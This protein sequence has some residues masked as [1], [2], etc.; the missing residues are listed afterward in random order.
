MM[1]LTN[2][3]QVTKEKVDQCF[4]SFFP[5]KDEKHQEVSEAVRYSFLGSG[6]ALRPF[7]VLETAKLFD[8]PES[9]AVHVACA[10]EM[11]HTY[12]LIHDDLPSMDNDD[13]RRGKPSCH[14]V[15]GEAI[16]I[17]A[18]DALLTK[19][20]EVL[21]SD[22][23]S[24]NPNIRLKLIQLLAKSAGNNGMIGG[25]V[26][27]LNGEKDLL[28][29]DEIYLMQTL[30]TGSL[31]HFACIASAVCADASQS[32]INHLTD[33]SRA[34]GL[35]FQTTDDILD[36][37]GNPILVGK[38]L[39]KDQEAKKSNFVTLLGLDQTKNLAVEMH[40][41]ALLALE[42]FGEKACILKE[43]TH[44]ILTRDH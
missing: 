12:S 18:G 20:F 16:A 39:H 41:N 3:L 28:C 7:L 22:K 6:K 24:L 10:I 25:Q 27:D 8:L 26:I 30:K 2:K 13:M 35:L 21:S 36:V 17:L 9:V 37:S 23:V 5:L 31:L 33:Y 40:K 19:A 38:T 11:V 4:S 29:V 15:F 34:I 14:K 32:L 44:F 1:N 42:P 43:L